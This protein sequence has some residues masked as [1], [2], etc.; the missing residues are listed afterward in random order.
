MSKN[1]KR[2]LLALL[3]LACLLMVFL[4]VSLPALQMQPGNLFR[5]WST[6]GGASGINP[7]SDNM[8]WFLVVTQVVIAALIIMLPIYIMLSLLNKEERKKLLANVIII[9]LFIL[10]LMTPFSKDLRA[11]QSTALPTPQPELTGQPDLEDELIPSPVFVATPKPWMLMLILI[12]AAVLLAGITFL[13]LKLLSD[14][15][16]AERLP[17]SDIAENAQAALTEIQEAKMEFDD[18]II[19]CYAEMSQTLQ[20]EKGIQRG[21]AMTPSEFEQKLLSRGFPPRPIRQLTKLFEQVRYGRQQPGE[22]E[23]Q[24]AV[25][26]LGEIIDF[27]KERA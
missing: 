16:A 24:A 1:Q 9:A 5:L 20:S 22:N 12:A 15:S 26:S 2:R 23:K 19:R 25:E 11:N 8:S 6:E 4:A 7:V 18:I 27:C 13:S 21:D 14:R 10:I 17:Y 3:L